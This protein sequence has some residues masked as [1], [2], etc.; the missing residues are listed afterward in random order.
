M[1]DQHDQSD[2]PDQPPASPS[3]APA[4]LHP[5]S[6]V[7][8]SRRLDALFARVE[9]LVSRMLTFDS[10]LS[11]QDDDDDVRLMRQF[12]LAYNPS[13]EARRQQLGKSCPGP[14]GVLRLR[15][16]SPGLQL[17]V[18]CRILGR[19]SD[20]EIG[21]R[22]GLCPRRSGSTKKLC[23]HVRD[24][25]DAIDWIWAFVLQP[26]CVN[27]LST[28]E[29]AL[30]RIAYICGPAVFEEILAGLSR[31]APTSEFIHLESQL[32]TLLTGGIRRFAILG[33][34]LLDVGQMEFEEFS[35]CARHLQRTAAAARDPKAESE[36]QNQ[37]TDA[38]R[39]TT[40]QLEFATGE[41]GDELY[42]Q[43]YPELYEFDKGAAELRDYQLYDVLRGNHEKYA[44]L[45]DKKMPP[46]RHAIDMP[47]EVVSP[48][49]DASP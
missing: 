32:D 33:L 27:N 39:E 16:N 42:R 38:I 15:E 41:A 26:E 34:N 4:S 29:M 20:V 19:Q 30:K 7:D 44:Y 17:A 10:R 47:D 13:S 43:K 22:T 48:P 18:Q 11:A 36:L 5:P 21:S 31:A 45:K 46:P 1:A 40:K 24:R 14:Y 28:V 12:L 3:P 8:P 49:A 23:F 25:L 37:L 35:K 2:A 6:P 9:S